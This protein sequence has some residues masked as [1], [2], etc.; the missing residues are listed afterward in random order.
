LFR[1]QF[2]LTAFGWDNTGRLIR[3]NTA[4]KKTDVLLRGLVAPNGVSLSKDGSF[5]V[6]AEGIAA[7]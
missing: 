1:R 2:I 3:Y 7:R 5:L 6:V 4:T